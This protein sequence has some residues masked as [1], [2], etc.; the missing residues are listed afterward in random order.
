MIVFVSVSADCLGFACCRAYI[1][2]VVKNSPID[3][4]AHAQ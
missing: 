1:F 2:P 4:S 3:I